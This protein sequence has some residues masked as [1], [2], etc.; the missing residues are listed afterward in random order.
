MQTDVMQS[1]AE[2]SRARAARIPDRR[3]P[4]KPVRQNEAHVVCARVAVDGYRVERRR[5]GTAQQFLQNRRSHSRIGRY[6]SQHRRHV[7]FDHARTFRDSAHTH[8]RAFNLKSDGYFFR[9]RVRCHDGLRDI[10]SVAVMK[11]CEGFRKAL[12]Y[13]IHRQ[14]MTDN[15]RACA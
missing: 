15:A 6:K 7:R 13:F 8:R 1:V 2:M 4:G 9:K 10:A 5:H 12:F 14:R 11:L 3:I